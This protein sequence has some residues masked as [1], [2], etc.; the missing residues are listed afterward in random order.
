MNI[1]KITEKD[2]GFTLIELLVV[3]S[4]IALLSVIVLGSL[5]DARSRGLD[6]KRNQTVSEYIN[7]IELYRSNNTSYPNPGNS[8]QYC[9]GDGT[10]TCHDI[11]TSPTRTYSPILNGQLET[12]LPRLPIDEMDISAASSD[13][14]GTT[15][16]CFTSSCD[17]YILRWYLTDDNKCIKGATRTNFINL[18]LCTYNPQ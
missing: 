15:Y 16:S 17:K 8:N 1:K 11:Y 6:T 18:K 13:M 14:S 10:G 2:S 12:Y 4:I 9:L 5:S 7:A 3:I